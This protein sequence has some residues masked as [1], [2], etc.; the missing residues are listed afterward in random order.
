M[1]HA[2]RAVTW[3]FALQTAFVSAGMGRSPGVGTRKA[4]GSDI[5]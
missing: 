2:A 5:R 3:V 4:V 1:E